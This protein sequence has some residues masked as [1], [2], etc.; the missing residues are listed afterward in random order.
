MVN[1]TFGANVRIF[2][3]DSAAEGGPV[4]ANTIWALDAS[5]AITKITN[6]SA[7]YNAIEEYAM[8]RSSALRLDWSEEC[9][10]TLGDTELKPFDSLVISA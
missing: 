5:I 4:P 9:F 1:N 6:T 7:A 3:V 10:R 2:L 8:K